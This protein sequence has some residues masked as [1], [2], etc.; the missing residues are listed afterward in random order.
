MGNFLKNKSGKSDLVIIGGFLLLVWLL[1]SQS[2]TPQAAGEGASGGAA[3][4][5]NT[6]TVVG[7][8]CTQS[9]TL[10]G[11]LVRRYTEA[12]QTAENV[13]IR[14]NGVL[15]ATVAHAGT[16]TVQSGPNADDLELF[17][18]L[19]STTFYP[20]HFKGKLNTCTAAATTGDP[21]FVEVNDETPG[22]AKISYVDETGLSSKSPNKLVQIDTVP[23]I[24]IVNDGQ[25]DQNTGG[26]GQGTG[27]NLTIG[28]GGSGSVTVKFSP[29]A[30][31]GW[32]IHGSILA[33]QFPSAVY[34][35]SNPLTVTMI[36]GGSGVLPLADKAPS[37]TVFPLIGA[38]N[39]VKAF[40]FPGIDAKRTGDVS[41]TL[42]LLADGN[43]N[44]GGGLDRVNCTTADVGI[45]QKKS[46]EYVLDVENRDTNVDLAG[47]NTVYDFEVGVA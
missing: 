4:T 46:G 18:G 24:T 41:F 34:D 44:P 15:K 29:G 2:S 35:A 8:P 32:G 26:Q 10:T 20:R 1:G 36:T 25:A 28:S 7:A 6:V 39:T 40:R 47:K 42:K 21:S 22:G 9:T 31:A 12:A 14:Q 30:E 23:T 19:E 43:H 3:P 37:N 13:T 27:F 33:C 45:Y 11:S 16:T 38:N 17:P 5:G